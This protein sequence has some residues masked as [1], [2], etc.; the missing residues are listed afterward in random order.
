MGSGVMGLKLLSPLGINDHMDLLALEV[1]L[2]RLVEGV[3][4]NLADLNG[5]DD[6]EFAVDA[7]DGDH[8]SVVLLTSRSWVD[9]RL[10]EDEEIWNVLLENIL[11]NVNDGGIELHQVMILVENHIC[12]W[13]MRGFIQDGLGS[14]GS[15][16]LPLGDLVV[17]ILWDWSLDDLRD[18]IGWD[19]V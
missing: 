4:D 6:L 7:L 18:Q 10:I 5:I 19:S 11:E 14:L 2:E 17:K 16:L 15:P 1:A 3:K 8:T 9:G 12:F 13:K